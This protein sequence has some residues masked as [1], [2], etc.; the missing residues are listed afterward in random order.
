MVQKREYEAWYS[1]L[2]LINS[3]AEVSS[4]TLNGF[5][6]Q[7]IEIHASEFQ[8]QPSP[9][10]KSDWQVGKELIS[11]Q[12]TVHS[13]FKDSPEKHFL[14]DHEKEIC[15]KNRKIKVFA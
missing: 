8:H 3:I 6:S 7:N 14:N 15:K 5:H 11:L 2:K 9:K 1:T 12:Q 13:S 4:H 10:Q